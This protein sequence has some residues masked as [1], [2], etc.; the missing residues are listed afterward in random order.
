MSKK[1]VM[2]QPEDTPDLA[3][4]GEEYQDIPPSDILSADE[5]QKFLNIL[6]QHKEEVED[7]LNE[8]IN[9]G[10]MVLDTNEM[11]DK[12]DLASA[13]VEQNVTLKLLY[14]DR[15]LLAEIEHALKKF[16]SGDFGYCEGTGDPIPAKRLE[17]TPWARYS[18]IHK[19]RLERE[20]RQGQN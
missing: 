5:L 18:V 8:R 11:A 20:K 9:S 2:S 4:A 15:R 10:D 1:R 13:N 6:L 16:I 14:R 12:V 7:R 17:L 19:E 3:G